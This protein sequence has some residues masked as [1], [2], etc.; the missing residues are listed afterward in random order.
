MVWSIVANPE[1]FLGVINRRS[2]NKT[3]GKSR[4][5]IDVR[6]SHLKISEIARVI[7]RSPS[8]ETRGAESEIEGYPVDIGPSHD[9]G[10]REQLE[11][12]SFHRKTKKIREKFEI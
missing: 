12:C 9:F 8:I 1:R 11:K 7:V 6:E 2:R 3:I 10:R 4:S 5:R